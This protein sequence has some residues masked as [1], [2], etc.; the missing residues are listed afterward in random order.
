[1]NPA[2]TNNISSDGVIPAGL[3]IGDF[4]VPPDFLGF[5][6]SVLFRGN[7]APVVQ[8]KYGENI[9][10]GNWSES[11]VENSLATYSFV[12]QA[13]KNMTGKHF[14]FETNFFENQNARSSK[15]R[16][17]SLLHTGKILGKRLSYF[18]PSSNILR[19]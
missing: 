14:V 12:I 17:T 5:N 4:E 10:A 2:C 19:H 1:M 3:S 16:L 15:T 9:A 13:T 18:G 8:W 7:K 11:R 6:C